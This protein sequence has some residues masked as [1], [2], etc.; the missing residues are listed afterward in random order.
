MKSRNLTL[1]EAALLIPG[2]RGNA[3]EAE[4]LLAEAIEY[5]NLPASIQ[6]WASEQWQGKQLP[7]NLNPLTTTI[8]EAE[9]NAWFEKRVRCE[10]L[11]QGSH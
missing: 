10:V 7:G 6:R 5:G 4:S 3:H 1:Q 11:R 9:L 2:H 8:D